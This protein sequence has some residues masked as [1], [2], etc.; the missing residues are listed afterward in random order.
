M[1]NEKGA[2]TLL[3]LGTVIFMM[4]FLLSSFVIISNR[5]Q[6]QAEIKKE[7][8]KSYSKDMENVEDIY[9]GYFALE[10][11][12]VPITNAEQL[13]SIGT[14][15]EFAV[16]G[17]IYKYTTDKN[18]VLKGNI[19]F[20]IEEYRN[21]YGNRIGQYTV[22]ESLVYTWIGI[23]TLKTQGFLTGNFDGQD[24]EIQISTAG[25]IARYNKSNNFS[26]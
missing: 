3:T 7:T 10:T 8:A 18:Y 25:K 2:I 5:L 23:N 6:S 17:K 9:K 14:G 22:D 12:T 21:K 11:D 24:Y 15:K 16:D 1:K 13:L 20:N 26:N 19:E 4:A